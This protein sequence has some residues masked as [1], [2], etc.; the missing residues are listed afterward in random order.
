MSDLLDMALKARENSYSPYSKFS[1]GACI[2][3]ESGKLYAGANIENASYSA[4]MCAERV[5][6]FKAISEGEKSFIKIAI[7]GSGENYC[8][9]C[10]SCLQV[11]NEF[12]KEDLQVLLINGKGEQKSLFLKDLLPYAFNGKS[13]K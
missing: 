13:L 9:P 7:C 8:Y 11:L 2:E 4:T 3:G 10:G 12:C 1:V 6:I 5:A